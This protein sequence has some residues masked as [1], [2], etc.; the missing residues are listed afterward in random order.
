MTLILAYCSKQLIWRFK[1]E[2][3]HHDN[4]KPKINNH[5]TLLKTNDHD[6]ELEMAN[7]HDV[8]EQNKSS[9]VETFETPIKMDIK[10]TSKRSSKLKK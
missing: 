6:I 9:I 2:R 3:R 8:A 10:P 4:T 5:L 7:S 1:T